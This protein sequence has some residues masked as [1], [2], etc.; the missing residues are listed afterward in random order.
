[1]LSHGQSF[2]DCVGYSMIVSY[3]AALKQ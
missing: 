3:N 2:V 1:L